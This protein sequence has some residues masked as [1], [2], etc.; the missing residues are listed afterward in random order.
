MPT[1]GANLVFAL[2][3]AVSPPGAHE[4]R[5]YRGLS[6]LKILS[7]IEALQQDVE[8]P[9]YDSAQL[10]V[11]SPLAGEGQ[12]EGAAA[13]VTLSCILPHRGGGEKQA[14]LNP[15]LGVLSL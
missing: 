9:R 15:H 6:Q 8:W 3:P 5:P 13:L 12:G 10:Q 2:L 1:V 4:D 14:L 11:P 7:S